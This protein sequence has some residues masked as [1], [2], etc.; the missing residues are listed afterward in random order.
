MAMLY[1]GVGAFWTTRLIYFDERCIALEGIGRL[2][3]DY[4]G[5]TRYPC[6]GCSLGAGKVS[7]ML[8]MVLSIATARIQAWNLLYDQ[9]CIVYPRS[10]N[11]NL[12]VCT[13]L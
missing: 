5:F 1:R 12:L 6:Y 7:V 10:K 11:S 2:G 13:K 8:D 3:G 4:D 9:P